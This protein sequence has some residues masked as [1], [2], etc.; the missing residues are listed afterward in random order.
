M[1]KLELL[2][3]APDGFPRFPAAQVERLPFGEKEKKP[4]EA[5]RVLFS[6]LWD[7]LEMVKVLE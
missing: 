1:E 2:E 5:K 7:V 3:G 6:P 4:G